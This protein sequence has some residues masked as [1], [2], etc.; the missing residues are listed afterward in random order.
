MIRFEEVYATTESAFEKKEFYE[1]LSGKN[2]YELAVLDAPAKVP[3]D[4]TAVLTNGIFAFYKN[5]PS[6]QEEI[7]QDFFDSVLRFVN[8]SD[9]EL[10]VS[11]YL[12]FLMIHYEKRGKAPFAL[13]EEVIDL[14]NK[15][16][17][18][19]KDSLSANRNFEGCLYPNGLYGDI[20]RLNNTLETYYSIN[21]IK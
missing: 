18:E 15:R 4:W 19:R 3:T 5:N 14:F 9:L 12:I 11:S 8:G 21:M 6:K 7:K 1:L 17:R 20:E 2:G 13:S 16:L 10:W